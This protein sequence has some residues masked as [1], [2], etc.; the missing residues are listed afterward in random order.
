MIKTLEKMIETAKKNIHLI[1]EQI[2]NC[3]ECNDGWITEKIKD[4]YNWD[5]RHSCQYINNKLTSEYKHDVINALSALGYI[6]AKAFP[7]EYRKI[8]N[9]INKIKA[10]PKYNK[11]KDFFEKSDKKALWIHGPVGTGKTTILLYLKIKSMLTKQECRLIFENSFNVEYGIL[12]V[13]E[14]RHK[15]LIDDVR[16][17]TKHYSN[18]YYNLFNKIRSSNMK[19]AITS[20]Y[21]PK[22]W[23]DRFENKDDAIRIFDRM[24]GVLEVVEINGRSKR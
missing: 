1:Q 23:C 21:S 16:N 7:E 2:K 9:D 15:D 24:K 22:S 3:T 11:F 4:G 5:N 14:I 12:K 18:F 13:P 17:S 20:N 6:N 19:I 10:M 8:F